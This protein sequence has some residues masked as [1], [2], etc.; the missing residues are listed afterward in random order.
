MNET[1]A[2]DADLIERLRARGQRVTSQ[3]LVINRMLRA[4]DQHVTAEEVLGAVGLSG[5]PE[6][7]GGLDAEHAWKLHARRMALAREELG[8][9]ESERT[10]SDANPA[11]AGLRDRNL[12]DLEHFGAARP[13]DADCL[14]LR[15]SLLLVPR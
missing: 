3:R 1:E 11:V 10:D 7:Y 9:V 5:I 14:H 4:R 12:L 6:Q 8:S 15:S 13:M 2:I